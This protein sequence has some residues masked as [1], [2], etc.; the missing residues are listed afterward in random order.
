MAT[1]RDSV[2]YVPSKPAL[3]NGTIRDNLLLGNTNANE[4]SIR[5]VLKQV[6]LDV[7]GHKL[8][9]QVSNDERYAPSTSLTDG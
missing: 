5:E 9:T 8:D 6:N 1:L 4:Q 3:F 7:F 2:V